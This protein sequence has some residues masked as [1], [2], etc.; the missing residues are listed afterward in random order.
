MLMLMRGIEYMFL[1]QLPAGMADPQGLPAAAQFATSFTD[2]TAQRFD[3]AKARTSTLS[4]ITALSD[5]FTES[6]KQEWEKFF[7]EYPEKVEDIPS[8]RLQPFSTES[9][10][11]C[12]MRLPD[13][14]GIANHVV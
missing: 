9:L 1:L 14:T 3:I 7:D 13:G 8:E 4:I 2:S 6:K 12:S 10:P 5:R 11:A